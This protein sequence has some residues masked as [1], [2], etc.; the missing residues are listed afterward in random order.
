MNRILTKHLTT[1]DYKT[2]EYIITNNFKNSVQNSDDAQKP[3]SEECGNLKRTMNFTNAPAFRL[4]PAYSY[5]NDLA[6]T[7]DINKI[8]EEDYNR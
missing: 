2:G 6:N 3:F 5:E 7:I 4:N 8:S 1:K